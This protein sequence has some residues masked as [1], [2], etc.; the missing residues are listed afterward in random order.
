[1]WQLRSL[2]TDIGEGG[3][4][5]LGE[6]RERGEKDSGPS[7]RCPNLTEYSYIRLNTAISDCTN[8]LS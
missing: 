2:G 7:Y 8:A 6:K 5:E 4:G 1:M 3:L